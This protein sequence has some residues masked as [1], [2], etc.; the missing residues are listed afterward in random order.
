MITWCYAVNNRHLLNKVAAER[1]RKEFYG[2]LKGKYVVMA[3]RN[4]LY[5][6]ILEELFDG[7][8]EMMDFKHCDRNLLK[9]LLIKNMKPLRTK[10][11]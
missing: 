3:L 1:I 9:C 5:T 2:I 6:G 11:V 10:F 4:M 8:W 7:V